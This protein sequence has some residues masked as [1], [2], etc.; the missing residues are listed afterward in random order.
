MYTFTTGDT[1]GGMYSATDGR[2]SFKANNVESFSIT[3]GK[4]YANMYSFL[5]GD[6]DAAVMTSDFDNE[7]LFK[8]DDTDRF[9]IKP[10]MVQARGG[11]S[12]LTGDTDGGIFSPADGTLTFITNNAEKML[13]NAFGNLSI[14]TISDDGFKLNVNGA[15]KSSE[16]VE[17]NQFRLPGTA[18][19]RIIL[20]SSDG[21]TNRFGLDNYNGSFR[22]FREDYD[23]TNGSPIFEIN[24]NS[25]VFVNTRLRVNTSGNDAEAF[26]I[27]NASSD[28]ETFILHHP[29]NNNYW[30]F[31]IEP[32][33][34]RFIVRSHLNYY[35]YLDDN[36]TG[37][38]YGSDI[39]LKENIR[40]IENALDGV[41]KL[42]G[43]RYNFMGSDNNEIG[44]IAQEVREQFP[45]IV[46]E[47]ADG[48]LG[49]AYDHL[50]PI[51]IEAIKEQQ[52]QIEYLKAEIAQLKNARQ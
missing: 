27:K 5:T 16:R 28:K 4:V 13:L 3:N 21:A 6:G 40:P 32:S 17:A 26:A 14:G 18:G 29:T 12:F 38:H 39:R 50:A 33:T 41:L 43:V 44:V 51:L 2:I 34:N 46:S 23:G 24:D 19:A 20:F 11:Y 25:D 48:I 7:I 47:G 36:A 49:V 10:D 30:T 22:V 9:R 31:G 37:W 35:A 45:E 1:D 8:T 52:K 15:I 42:R